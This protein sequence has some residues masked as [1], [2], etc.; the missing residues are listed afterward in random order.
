MKNLKTMK[1]NHVKVVHV[2]EKRLKIGVQDLIRLK[3]SH[4]LMRNRI[5]RKLLNIRVVNNRLF[6]TVVFEI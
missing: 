2:Q 6:L 5:F 3:V 1:Q 4:L